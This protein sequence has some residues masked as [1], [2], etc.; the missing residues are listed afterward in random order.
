MEDSQIVDL[1]WQRSDQAILETEVKYGSYCRKIAANILENS[2]DSEEC[3]SDTWLS[4][5][6]SMPNNRPE[7]LLPYLGRICRN[8]ALD[9][10]KGRN[11]IK[12]GGRGK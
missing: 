9:I 8:H 3:V 11:K 10:L 2:E 1:Y 5:W 6:N 12:R 4:A 7:K